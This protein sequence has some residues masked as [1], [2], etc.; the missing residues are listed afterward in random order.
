MLRNGR[1]WCLIIMSVM[2]VIIVTSCARQSDGQAPTL[3]IP[4]SQQ[5]SLRLL[6]DSAGSLYNHAKGGEYEE[7]RMELDRFSDLLTTVSYKGIT[8]LEGVNA[9]TLTVVEAR[10]IYNRVQLSEKDALIAAT[11]LRL[12]ADALTHHNNPMWLEYEN[13]LKLDAEQLRG[14]IKMNNDVGSLEALK[15]LHNH[16]LIIHP[17]VIITRDVSLVEKVNSLFNFLTAELSQGKV[18]YT[19]VNQGINH[20]DDVLNEL[21]GSKDSQT[22]VPL[23]IE[24]NNVIWTTF[25]ASVII[26]SLAYVA[27]RRYKVL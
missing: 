15:K 27:W 6:N 7:A 9:L 13:V 26:S 19:N 22:L 25:I 3:V 2:I 24:Q 18:N 21:F 14:M 10:R 5:K 20:L 16:Y 12:I 8:T 17:S 1:Y 4:Q 23:M 11:Q